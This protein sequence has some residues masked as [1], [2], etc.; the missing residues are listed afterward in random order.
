MAILEGVSSSALLAVLSGEQADRVMK[1]AELE[2]RK[3]LDAEQALALIAEKSPEIA[4]AIA[5]ALK[6]K[7]SRGRT[8]VQE[9]AR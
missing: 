1:L 6:A 4:P 7:Y 3:G 9:E 8:D 2:M 5:E